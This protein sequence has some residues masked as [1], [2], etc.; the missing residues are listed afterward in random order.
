MVEFEKQDRLFSEL[1]TQAQNGDGVAYERLLT[2]ISKVIRGFVS[3][4]IANEQEIDDVVQNTLLA[5]HNASH[6][7]NTNR[8]FLSWMFAIAKYKMN[9][10]LRS[11]YKDKT[12]IEEG[13]YDD[14]LRNEYFVMTLPSST[15]L[16]EDLMQGLPD[17]QKKIVL[18]VKVDGYSIKDVAQ[19]L[20]VTESAVK[21]A[22]HRTYRW[23]IANGQKRTP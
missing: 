3:Q 22:A 18:M 10:S 4:R 16:L 6:T 8:S 23:L 12:L 21:V 9:D 13:M 19:H 2:A 1:M 14:Q 11:Y 15:D 7:Y 5:I 17:R 20:N